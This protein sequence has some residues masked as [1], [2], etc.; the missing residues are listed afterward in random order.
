MALSNIKPMHLTFLPPPNLNGKFDQK[1]VI[2]TSENKFNNYITRDW[3]H[4]IN[5]MHRSSAY[6]DPNFQ[7]ATVSFSTFINY[8]DACSKWDQLEKKYAK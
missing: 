8:L 1:R 2:I 5:G 7:Y 3:H 4:M 6:H